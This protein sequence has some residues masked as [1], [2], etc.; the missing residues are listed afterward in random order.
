MYT[1]CYFLYGFKAQNSWIYR[2]TAT[3]SELPLSREVSH[4]CVILKSLLALSLCCNDLEIYALR[5]QS[6]EINFWMIHKYIFENILISRYFFLGFTFFIF[7]YSWDKIVCVPV[8]INSVFRS[9]FEVHGLNLTPGDSYSCILHMGLNG[10]IV[11]VMYV[12]HR[13]KRIDV[14]MLWSHK[15][16]L[17]AKS[18]KVIQWENLLKVI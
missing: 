10:N 5:I 1:L 14:C 16:T 13:K 12:F 8:Y 4:S 15:L 2:Y 18:L 9:L 3:F 6:L 17:N 11:N 7:T